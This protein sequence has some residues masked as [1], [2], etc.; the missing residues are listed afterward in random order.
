MKKIETESE[1]ESILLLE[2]AMVFIF[3]EW[4]GQ[5]HISRNNV[6]D[7]ENKSKF[8]IPLF[9]LEPDELMSVSEWVRDE[10]KKR[11]G[12]GS[13]IWLKGGNI[14]GVEMYAGKFGISELERKTSEIFGIN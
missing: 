9:E 11:G 7:W 13:L 14:V 10:A 1:F 3:F 12:Y 5:A 8:E 2:K 6:L 4:S